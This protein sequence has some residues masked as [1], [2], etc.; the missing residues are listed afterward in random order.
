MKKATFFSALAF[1]ALAGASSVQAEG[2]TSGNP[3]LIAVEIENQTPCFLFGGYQLSLGMRYGHFRFRASTQDS[4]RADFEDTGI[5][6]RSSVFR[7]SYDDGSFS[8]SV[9]YFL[10]KC[11]FTYVCLGSN[12]WLVQNKDTLATDHL[13]TLDAGLGLGFQFFVY[14]GLFVQLAASINIRDRQSLIIE[15]EEYTVP[16]IDYSPGLQLGYKF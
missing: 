1:L 5:D 3:A 9:D 7:R 13:R 11:L 4:G 16:G 6:S 8:A 12:R 14:K 10:N 2:V 15:G